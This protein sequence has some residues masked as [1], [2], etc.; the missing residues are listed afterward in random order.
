M[1]RSHHEASA[2][3]KENTGKYKDPGMFNVASS[4]MHSHAIDRGKP[5]IIA[6]QVPTMGLE[7]A[8]KKKKKSSYYGPDKPGGKAP[9]LGS[10][11]RFKKLKGKI[12]AEGDVEDP[13]AVAAMIGRKKFGKKRFQEMAAAGK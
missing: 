11:E 5:T 4:G 8:K 3:H 13:E 9:P 10:G 2:L 6:G 12:S 1:T 7:K